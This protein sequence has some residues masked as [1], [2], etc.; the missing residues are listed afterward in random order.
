MVPNNWADLN[1]IISSM[2]K[3]IKYAVSDLKSINKN[4]NIEN[5]LG[6]MNAYLNLSPI[7][8]LG[9]H[10]QERLVGSHSS[11]RHSREV[12]MA[13]ISAGTTLTST[14]TLKELQLKCLPKNSFYLDLSSN[15]GGNGR[16]KNLRA[17]QCR[18]SA[19][20]ANQE[21]MA[22]TADLSGHGKINLCGHPARIFVEKTARHINSRLTMPKFHLAT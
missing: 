19:L 22:N 13:T 18:K 5:I 20:M 21:Q 16:V 7:D 2:I 12:P 6:L 10:Y 17:K 9:N 8:E 15:K 3:K 14:I 1:M 11:M 4:I